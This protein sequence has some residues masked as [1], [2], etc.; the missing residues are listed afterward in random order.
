MV[1]TSPKGLENNI[2]YASTS[3]PTMEMLFS[4]EAGA[5]AVRFAG[6]L[7]SSKP[8]TAG[9]GDGLGRR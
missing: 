2:C 6:S 1:V 8:A 5:A 7:G 3:Y 4:T 9:N